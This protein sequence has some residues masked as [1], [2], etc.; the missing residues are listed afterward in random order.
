[1]KDF[2]LAHSNANG[3]HFTITLG[4]LLI[5]KT[6]M[7]QLGHLRSNRLFCD[8]VKVFNKFRNLF[9]Q[10][11]LELSDPQYHLSRRIFC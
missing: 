7:K 3:L 6:T 8:S 10:F 5:V 9:A 11:Q 2:E 1:M 4:R